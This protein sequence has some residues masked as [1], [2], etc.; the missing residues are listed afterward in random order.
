MAHQWRG[1]VREYAA[2][3]PVT[4][5]TR[6]I[7]L[8]EGGTPL[9]RAQALSALTGSEVYL[10]VEGMNPTG[11]FKDRGMTMAMTAA[12]AAGAKAVVCAST[13]NTSASAAAYATAAGLTCAVLV[14]AGKI[15]MGKLSQAVAHG[16]TLLQVDGNFDN[17]LDVA[18]KLADSYPVFLVN[19]VNPARIEGQKTG[20]F[21]VV[22]SLGDAPDIHVLPVGNAGN[23]SAYWKGY[24]EYCA[25]YESATAG[26]L[27]AV[28]TKTPI[29]WGFQAAGA[30]PFVAG[31]PITEPDTIATAIRIGNP[32]SWDLAVAARDESGGLIDSVTDEQIL[33]A[34]RWLSA[35]EGVFVEP[36]SAAGVA[37]LLKKHAAGEVPSG[38][39]IVITVTGHGLKDPDWA[40]KNADG[41]SIEPQRVG[42]DVVTVAAAL[43]LEGEAG[44]GV[45]DGTR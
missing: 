39:T 42:F 12:V 8:G 9:V 30:A 4:E 19:S 20:A 25:P 24:K 17:C 1:V 21:E 37:G 40:L 11:S 31:H 29:M 28:S 34:H 44:A 23:I 45:D 33:Q 16:A 14:P 27:P 26:T 22:D 6:V 18:R 41:S 15:S 32:A 13:G 7:T 2:R 35:K 5:T 43:G 10:K 3:L 36:A 38:K